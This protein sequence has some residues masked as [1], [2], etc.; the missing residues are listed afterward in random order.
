MSALDTITELSRAWYRSV[1]SISTDDALVEQGETAGDVAY[2]HLTRGI[3]AAQR[4]MIDQGLGHRWRKRSGAITSWSGSED[5]DGGRYVELSTTASDF[6]RLVQQKVRGQRRQ[7]GGLVEA[8]GDPWGWEI[9]DT[10]DYRKGD[11][12]YLKGNRV[13]I[14]RSA[15][16]ASTLYLQ[17]YY[18]HP[19][20]SADTASFD[21][22]SDAMWV[23]LWEAV[24]SAR[25][26]AWFPLAGDADQKIERALLKARSEARGVARQTGAPRQWGRPTRYGN[27]W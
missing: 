8:N 4:W 23:A 18:Q 17:Y 2:L 21:F 24:D 6:L 11:L 20:L 7:C 25:S 3:R 15:N 10:E 22:P 9:D 14:T 12:Y 27:R 1:G 13:W 16:P 19:A 5:S 26:E